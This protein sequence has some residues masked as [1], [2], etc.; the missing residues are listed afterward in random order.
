MSEQGIGTW[1]LLNTRRDLSDVLSTIVAERS[2]FLNLFPAGPPATSIKHEW[3]EK[4]LKPK[5]IPYTAYNQSTGTFTVASSAGWRVGDIVR[6]KGSPALFTIA[7]VAATSITVT[8]LASNG[9]SVSDLTGIGTGAG[10]LL[11]DSAPVL[12]GSLS[13]EEMFSQT[14]IEYNYTQIVRG[15]IKISNTAL[16]VKTVGN[17]NDVTYQLNEAMINIM[18]QLNRIAMFGSRSSSPPSELS[19]SRAGGLYY[20]GTQDGGLKVNAT[21]SGTSLPLS[22][23]IINDAAQAVLNAG[24]DPDTVICSPGQAR[25]I[26]Q[27]LRNQITF[28]PGDQTRGQFVNKILAESTGRVMNVVVEP[29]MSDVDTDVWVVDSTSLG[30]CYL[31]GREIH[32]EPS[33][34]P[35]F[36]GIRTS[37]IGEMT[38]VFK[39]AKQKLCQIT[40][41]LGSDAALA[42]ETTVGGGG[43]TSGGSGGTEGGSGG[44]TE[45]GGGTSGGTEGGGG[46]SG[47]GTTG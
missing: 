23:K 10:I 34:A 43:G 26:S 40:G 15:E 5:S 1:D 2:S 9:T 44:G 6:V 12:Q 20:F 37:I 13:G 27:L 31:G 19:P 28:Q 29:M 30:M 38:F 24:G 25:V 7:S 45:G 42:N 41:L 32:T 36:D 22:L 16:A 21:S 33:T 4:V 39:N 8:F 3:A 17:E 11:F 35:G 47:G 14:G 46:T 18:R